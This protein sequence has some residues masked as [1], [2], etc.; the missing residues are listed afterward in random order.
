MKNENRVGVHWIVIGALLA[1]S[2]VILG[3]IGAHGLENMIQQMDDQPK[4]LANW[5][6]GVRY[7]MHHGMALI[8]LGILAILWGGGRWITAAGILF[9]TG[10][11]FFSCGLYI[12]VFTDSRTIVSLVPL[13]G[14]AFILG[15]VCVVLQVLIKPRLK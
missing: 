4:R 2:G 1:G 8:L 10:I 3:S 9:L 13:G 7:Q 6:T 15:W 12:W 11:L 5:D 14:L